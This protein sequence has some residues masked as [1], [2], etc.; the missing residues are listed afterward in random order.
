MGSSRISS[1]YG[2]EN[3]YKN[4]M[5][6]FMR[7]KILILLVLQGTSRSLKTAYYVLLKMKQL[8][9]HEETGHSLDDIRSKMKRT[10]IK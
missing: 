10:S 7:V 9:I 3:K 5:R 8:D 6:V 2:S 4:Q 1:S